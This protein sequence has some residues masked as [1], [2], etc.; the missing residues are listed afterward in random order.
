MDIFCSVPV[1]LHKLRMNL[2]TNFGS[3]LL[4]NH[5]GSL[6]HG[7]TCCTISP[8]VSS[9]IIASLHGMNIAALLQS[10][11]VIV[12][13]E[14]YPCDTGSLVM[15]SSTT[16][17]KGIASGFGYIGCRGARVGRVLILCHWHSVHPLTYSITSLCM[18]GHQYLLLVS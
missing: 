8:A 15:K 10:W 3:R 12:S 11:L 14:S 17:S 7:N 6:K 16:V 13:M 2:D 18:F 5:C 1:P 4:I 9:A